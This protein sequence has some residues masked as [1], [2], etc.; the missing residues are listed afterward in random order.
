MFAILSDIHGNYEALQA[1]L[2]DIKSAGIEEIVCLGDIVGYGPNPAE[3]VRAARDFDLVVMG[4]HD[5]AALNGPSEFFTERAANAVYWTANHLDDEDM[6]FISGFEEQFSAKRFL[7]VHG[8]PRNP[9]SEYLMP[10]DPVHAPEKMQESFD[11]IDGVCFV[12]HTHYAG[13]FLESTMSFY[14]AADIDNSVALDPSDKAIVNVG[15]VGQPRDGNPKA[16][17]AIYDQS[18]LWWRRVAYDY[19]ATMEKIYSIPHLDNTLGAR[20]EQGR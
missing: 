17:Y 12:G 8:S 18:N 9:I 20:L 13:L 1:V 11:L 7:Y 6:D 2:R 3:C 4:N 5:Y 15:S 10:N 16:C 19:K 14:K